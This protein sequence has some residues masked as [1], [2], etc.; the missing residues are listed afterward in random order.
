MRSVL[1][2]P[3]RFEGRLHWRRELLLALERRASRATTC[4]SGGASPI[5][6]R[7][8]CRTSGW[9]RRR[10]RHE[11]LRARA[12]NLELLDEL[13]AAMTDAGELQRAVRSHL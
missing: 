1:G 9:P 12:A 3:V 10:G 5:T 8:R 11:E 2:L 7:S 4:S 13:L 6:S